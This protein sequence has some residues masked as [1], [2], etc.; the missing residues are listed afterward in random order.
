MGV[1]LAQEFEWPGGEVSKYFTESK[2]ESS[3][4][5]VDLAMTIETRKSQS[6][7][8]RALRDGFKNNDISMKERGDRRV[9]VIERR[10]LR[11]LERGREGGEGEGEGETK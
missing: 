4:V 5:C 2:N 8:F 6:G 11:K 3:C 1:E 9:Y 10:G 7:G